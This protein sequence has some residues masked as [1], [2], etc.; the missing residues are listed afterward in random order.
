[1]CA[2]KKEE[3]PGDLVYY[4]SHDGFIL[5]TLSTHIVDRSALGHESGLAIV[6]HGVPVSGRYMQ[7]IQEMVSTPWSD[8]EITII[9]TK[10]KSWK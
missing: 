6:R 7:R 8:P 9:R 3:R 4:N 1:M 10:R 5:L 2:Q